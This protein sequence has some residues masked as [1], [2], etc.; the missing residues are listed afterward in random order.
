MLRRKQGFHSIHWSSSLLADSYWSIAVS[1]TWCHCRRSAARR[2]AHWTPVLKCWTSRDTVLNHVS[3][4]RPLGLLHPACGLLIAA[5]TTLWWSS[6]HDLLARW[7]KSSSLLMRTNLEAAE[8]PLV[9]LTSA[10]V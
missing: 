3:R 4:G 5:T 1:T 7:P 9:L 6:S 8:H 10:F 2:Q